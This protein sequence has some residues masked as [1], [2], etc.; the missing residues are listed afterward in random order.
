MSQL[1][2][3]LESLENEIRIGIIGIGSIGTGM[4]Y[5][6]YLTP[7]MDCVA[8]CDIQIERATS[9]LDWMGR[10]YEIVSSHK[11]MNEAIEQGK[12][13][14]TADGQLLASCDLLDVC[15]EATNTI[16]EGGHHAEMAINAGK[17]AIMMNYEADLIFGSYLFNLAKEKGVV[18]T[19]ADGDQ[20]TVVKRLIDY[21]QFM[22]FELVMAGNI[23]GYLDRY[24]NPTMIV[25]EADKR[26]LDYRMCTSY[27]D[28][29]KLCIEMSVL[30]NGLGLR[31]EVP[32]ML[33][34]RIDH[35]LDI[36]DVIN[37]EDVWDGKQAIVDFVL[38]AQPTGGVF[39]VGYTDKVYQQE[40]LAWFPPKLGP[41]PFYIFYR[42]FH[43][44][45]FETMLGVAEA[46]LDGYGVLQP[47]A[48][49]QTNVYSYAKSDLHRGDTLDGIGGYTCYG[50]I[51]NCD[52]D[53]HKPGIPICL[54]DDM[55][56]KRDIPQDEKIFLDDVEFD[57]NTNKWV[58][59]NKAL[60][61]SSLV[62][63][64]FA[65]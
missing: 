50:L 29:T 12:V 5:Q 10:E 17:H 18:Y 37:F 31:T 49:F 9:C 54:S 16:V 22:G 8:V 59:Y 3:R 56:L 44:G 2:T 65:E 28:G 27:T 45:H 35:V 14:V 38:G 64:S 33:G 36:F 62:R 58:L 47:H 1:I 34:P 46:A 41:G 55:I 42:P 53:I 11:S 61:Q 7:G 26:N 13:A 4:V 6:G 60:E 15:I 21:V 51:E 48:G 20:P 52:E 63:H 40:T 24:A 23:K 19:S 43:L 25:P 32:G 57:P 30:A 39:V